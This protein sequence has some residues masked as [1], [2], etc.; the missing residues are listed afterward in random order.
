MLY[1]KCATGRVLG[2]VLENVTAKTEGKH[3]LRR[4]TEAEPSKVY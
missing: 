2:R 4:L 1:H 3:D